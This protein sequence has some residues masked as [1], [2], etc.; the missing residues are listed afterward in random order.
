MKK[1]TFV[2]SFLLLASCTSY[3]FG[4]AVTGGS[5]GGLFGS[6]IGGIIGGPRGHDAGAAL[7]ILAGAAIGAAAT[8][9]KV[10]QQEEVYYYQS[11]PKSYYS[12]SGTSYYNIEVVNVCFQGENNNN[13]LDANERAYLSM[14]I[15]NR[16]QQTYYDI[17]P[18][19]V[20]S[21]SKV[22]ISPATIISQLAPDQGVHYRVALVGGKRMKNEV[23]TFKVYVGSQLVR[24][25]HLNQ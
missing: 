10:D 5:L 24:T 25:F 3:Q 9:P 22:Q 18:R 2:L 1:F 11:Q 19:I 7:G 20:C 14:D 21:S 23:L 16:G 8:A 15:Y 12:P 17:S 6:A 13:R 4:G